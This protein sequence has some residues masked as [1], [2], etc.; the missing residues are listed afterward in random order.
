[1]G[2]SHYRGTP[3]MGKILALFAPSRTVQKKL[4]SVFFPK[5]S[6]Q[7]FCLS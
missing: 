6:P 3:R 2:V 7:I 4:G 1:M 5:M